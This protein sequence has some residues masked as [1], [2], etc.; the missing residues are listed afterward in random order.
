MADINNDAWLAGTPEAA[1]EPELPICDPHHHLWDGK[2]GYA[3]P[4]YFV[5]DYMADVAG[6]HNIVSSVFI[7]CGMMFRDKGPPLM[8]PVGETEF[9]N[10]QAAMAAT[11]RY[12]ATRVAA[13]IVGTAYLTE[14]DSVAAVLDAQLAASKRFRGI[15]QGA[16]F[17]PSDDVPNH[18][19]GPPEGML[20]SAVFREG[21]AHLA[22]RNLSFEAWCYHPQIPQVTALARAF[23]DT[24]IVLD[25]FGGPIGVGPYARRRD[26]VFT[27]WRDSISELASCPNVYAKLGGL[28]MHV[29]GFGWDAHDKPPSSEVFVAPN[30]PYYEHTIEAFGPA[31]CMFESNFPVD[32]ASCS[33]TVLW[34]AFKRMTR[35][36]SAGDRAQLFH[37]TAVSVYRL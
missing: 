5:E 16:T 15:R 35:D 1:L 20:E 9:A 4:R 10:G 18:R 24:T 12:G 34:N 31:R 11:G 22:S 26:D 23:P 33:F 27:K 37:D 13:G 19:T 6:G 29:N 8:R 2:V 36:Y 28:A 3:A 32:R 14:G 17:D 30:R 21:F 7:E 25:H